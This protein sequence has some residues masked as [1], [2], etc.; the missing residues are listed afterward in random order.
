MVLN[1]MTRGRRYGSRVY[2]VLAMFPKSA[3]PA[4]VGALIDNIAASFEA[5]AGGRPTRSVGALMGPGA[6]AGEAGYIFEADFR[7]LEDAMTALD[8]EDFQDA[9][10]RVEALT[11]TIFLFEVQEG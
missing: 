10:T 7:S 11:S 3:D 9:K 8:A 5:S 6:E 2:R 1:G 4:E